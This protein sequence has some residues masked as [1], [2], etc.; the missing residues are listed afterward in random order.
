V[1]WNLLY[2]LV[3]IEYHPEVSHEYPWESSFFGPSLLSVFY[4]DRRWV[5]LRFVGDGRD[6]EAYICEY[7]VD[8]RR[9]DA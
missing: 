7:R 8:V 5:S 3:T 1:E 2:I 9:P 6:A 4:V